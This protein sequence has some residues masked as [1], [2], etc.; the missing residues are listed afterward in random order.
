MTGTYTYALLEVPRELY[1][2][3]RAKLREAGYPV[4][5]GA[6]APLDM[7]GLALTPDP[8]IL[9]EVTE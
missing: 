8:K 6:S 3:V 1:D 9:K 4:P 7:H 2:L 5:V